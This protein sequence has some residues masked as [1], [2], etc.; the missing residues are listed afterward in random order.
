MLSNNKTSDSQSSKKSVPKIDFS[1]FTTADGTVVSTKERVIKG[2]LHIWF[3]LYLYFNTSIQEVPAPAVYLPTEEQ[4]WS[5]DRPG[6]PDINFLKNHF[7]REGR[8]S[9]SQAL[10]ILDKGKEL[11]QLENNLLDIPAPITGNTKCSFQ[12]N[13]C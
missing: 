10:F 11:L 8:V 2:I 4:F 9:E 13:L 12:E 6:L 7:F 3:S 1:L 5:K